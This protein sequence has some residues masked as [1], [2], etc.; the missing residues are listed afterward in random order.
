MTFWARNATALPP[1]LADLL[2]VLKAPPPSAGG[3]WVPVRR[4]VGGEE[5][6]GPLPHGL[7]APQKGYCVL[8]QVS[9]GGKEILCLPLAPE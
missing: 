9:G 7:A 8:R 5:C 3:S 2:S 6:S 4:E 1:A